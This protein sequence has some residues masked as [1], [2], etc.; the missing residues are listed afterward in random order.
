M[1]KQQAGLRVR[2]LGERLGLP[3]FALD[4]SNTAMIAIAD[5]PIVTVGYAAAGGTL[6]LMICLD[7]VALTPSVMHDALGAN[8]AGLHTAGGA[9]AIDPASRALVLR[10]RCGDADAANGGLFAALEALVAAAEAWQ[11]RLMSG[12]DM[13]SGRQDT[14]ATAIPTGMVRA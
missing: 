5:G 3:D 1:D 6:E 14:S 4:D 12:D 2:E 11:R 9:F 8:F 13:P 10:R 7:A